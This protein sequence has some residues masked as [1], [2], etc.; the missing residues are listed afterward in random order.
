[1]AE[2]VDVP[3]PPIMV[4]PVIGIRAVMVVSVEG[5]EAVADDFSPVESV[6]RGGVPLMVKVGDLL[7][8]SPNT[9]FRDTLASAR[10]F[11]ETRVAHEQRCSLS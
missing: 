9:V 3:V 4:V 7:P 1:M 8:E 10:E 11:E 2:A 6:V 5:P